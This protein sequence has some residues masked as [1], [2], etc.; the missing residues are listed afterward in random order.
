LKKFQTEASLPERARISMA[1]EKIGAYRIES[2]LGRGGMG[3]VFLAWDDR[4]RRRV[5]IKRIRQDSETLPALRERFL[6]EARAA[7]GLSHPAIVQVFDLLE[8]ASGDAIVMEYVEGRTLAE[9]LDSGPLDLPQALR[10]AREIA[11]G[12]AAAHAAGIV[13]RDLKAENVI[14]TTAGHAK[15]LDFGLARAAA[16]SPGETLTQHGAVIG[17]FHVMSPEQASGL[18]VDPRSDLFSFGA[19]LYEMLTGRSP[20]RGASAIETLKRVVTETPPPVRLIRPDVPAPLSDLV[21]RL[22]EKEPEDRPGSAAEVAAQLRAIEA[23]GLPENRP[24][25]ETLSDLP[26]GLA[27]VWKGATVQAIPRSSSSPP[28]TAGMSI[29]SRRPRRGT[30]A[31]VLALVALTAGTAYVLLDRA[32]KPLRVVVPEPEVVGSEPRLGL[33]ASAVLSASLNGLSSLEGVTPIAPLAGPQGSAAEMIRMEAAD[34]VLIATLEGVGAVGRVTL[35]RI[36]GSGGGV[37]WSET[38]DVPLR[39]GDLRLIADAVGIHLRRGYSDREPRPGV[40]PLEARDEDYSAFLSVKDRLD[41]GETALAPE[42]ER[43]ERILRTSP[44]FLEA[45]LLAADVALSLFGSTREISYRDRALSLVQQARAL[46]PGDPRPLQMRFKIAMSGDRPETAEEVLKEIETLLPGDPETLAM[47]AVLAQRLGRTAEALAGW[48]AAVER[49]PSWRSLFQLASLE[50]E[51]GQIEESRRHF[52]RILEISPGNRWALESLARL[53]LFHGDL[54]RAEK[55]Y[56]DLTAKFPSQRASFTNLGI[57]RALLGRHD[58]AVEA[59]RQALAIEPDH[60]YATLNLADSELALGLREEAGGH[61]RKVLRQLERNRPPGGLPAKDSLVEAQCLA[62]LGQA[63]KAVE[64]AQWG[65]RQSPDDPQILYAA[66]LVYSL[67]GDRASALVSARKAIEKGVQARFFQVPA[68]N[69]L[70][71]DPELRSLLA[72]APDQQP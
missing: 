31:A 20:F 29:P 5:A 37:L 66:A 59:Y 7:A 18:D 34:E 27:P 52:E 8:D 32:A 41:A 43:L 14:V 16:A 51:A 2:R 71:G 61:Y 65:L 12:L 26:T 53:E 46:A 50:A 58:K 10:L 9:L 24:P 38:F 4:L 36:Q 28:S 13:H 69:G 15:I 56:L 30:V 25:E 57:A 35:R 3:E 63:S 55:L 23:A 42:L 49:A 11:E 40:P 6:R 67:V 47:R 17:T 45:R 70:R 22:L 48:H 33:A 39:Q 54:E 62:R 44:R 68:F 19:V 1:E 64:A 60:V 72:R 21:V